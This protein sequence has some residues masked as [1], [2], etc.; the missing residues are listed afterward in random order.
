MPMDPRQQDELLKIA[1]GRVEW[2][3]SMA[4]RTTFRVGGTAEALCEI[5]ELENLCRL[6][7]Y[8][9]EQHI[10][11]LVIGRGSNLLV[12]DGGLRGVVILLSGT[13]GQ[14]DWGTSNGS[15]TVAG[16]GVS[17][18]DL[19]IGCRRR[20][21]SGL[22][23]L[24]GIP[25]TVGGAVAMNAGAFGEEIS[26]WIRE[27]RIVDPQ[28]KVFVVDRSRLAFSYRRLD[29]DQGA[30]IVQAAFRLNRGSETGVAEKISRCLKMRKGSQPLEYPS[31]GSVFR[32]PP[33]DYAGR[34]I[35]QA[36]LKGTSIG[37]A[38][39]SE[40][41]ANFIINKGGASASDIL[42]LIDAVKETVRKTAGVTL[43]LEIRVVGEPPGQDVL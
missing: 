7:T 21:L 29:I 39:V 10:P 12:R 43:K 30:V 24:A 33:N 32:N 41:H 5:H 14:I 34:L 11:Y 6:L 25:G 36:G 37:G 17:L 23:F 16:A 22:E 15:D 1:V 28:G 27:L 9:G 13:L 4:R 2:N 3:A 8:L 40:R 42:A 20:G 18:V 38:M 19:L 31:A 35:E 26:A